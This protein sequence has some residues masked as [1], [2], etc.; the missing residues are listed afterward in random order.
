MLLPFAGFCVSDM[1]SSFALQESLQEFM[2]C[3]TFRLG[4]RKVPPINSRQL[5]LT[6]GK[7]AGGPL[8]KAA[9][10]KREP[11]EKDDGC[12]L[13]VTRMMDSLQTLL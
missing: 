1:G 4:P 2:N 5:L 3:T 6:M 11:G 12:R 8:G 9:K 13:W 10:V 7:R